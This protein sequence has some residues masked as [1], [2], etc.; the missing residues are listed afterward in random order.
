[1]FFPR[2]QMDVSFCQFKDVIV[3]FYFVFVLKEKNI[4]FVFCK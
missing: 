3:L 2:R 1:M 4:N